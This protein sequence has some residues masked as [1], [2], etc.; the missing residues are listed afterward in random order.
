M[1]D[2]I[3]ESINSMRPLV[4]GLLYVTM[5]LAMLLFT[6]ML[7]NYLLRF[8]SG[9]ILTSST[10]TISEFANLND[11]IVYPNN[12]AYY[13]HEILDYDET[14]R[15]PKH[16]LYPT[17]LYEDMKPSRI[18]DWKDLQPSHISSEDIERIRPLL[19]SPL[20]NESIE[21]IGHMITQA[22]EYEKEKAKILERQKIYEASKEANHTDQRI[23]NGR[24]GEQ[25]LK[26]YQA[27]L[28]ADYQATED[29]IQHHMAD[30]Q[31]IIQLHQK[32]SA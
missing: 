6:M 16:D 2:M 13:V 10:P 18:I 25:S 23:E 8:A 1:F 20:P 28:D 17:D 4:Y 29:K 27:K 11:V 22:R 21:K 31:N 15:N 7:V 30:M 3:N 24:I 32:Q 26:D 14:I 5:A 19:S 9:D 12:E